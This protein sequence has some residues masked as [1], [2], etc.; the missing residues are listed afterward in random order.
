M[1]T[2]TWKCHLISSAFPGKLSFKIDV[3]E[4][5][6]SGPDFGKVVEEWNNCGGT[7]L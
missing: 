4:S 2:V 5:P 6:T 1:E 3:S 7:Q